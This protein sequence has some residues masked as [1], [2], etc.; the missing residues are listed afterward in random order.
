VPE[1]RKND[2]PPCAANTPQKHPPAQRRQPRLK[3]VSVRCMRMYCVLASKGT[4]QDADYSLPQQTTSSCK[5]NVEHS[6]ASE[7]KDQHLGK[8]EKK[9]ECLDNFATPLR[10]SSPLVPRK[11]GE[12]GDEAKVNAPREMSTDQPD[13][14]RNSALHAQ[15][16]PHTRNSN[17]SRHRLCR[18]GPTQTRHCVATQTRTA[19]ATS[20][21]LATQE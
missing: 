21:W 12:C 14:A 19:F 15:P 13:H 18:S 10:R 17:S 16:R 5:M 8:G 3:Q 9:D 20:T 7:G 4:K 11:P 1:L 2:Y 6:S